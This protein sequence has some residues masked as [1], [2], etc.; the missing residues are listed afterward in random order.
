MPCASLPETPIYPASV[1]ERAQKLAKS[2]R[3]ILQ[4]GRSIRP[5]RQKLTENHL[6]PTSPSMRV[7][8]AV[9][10]SE[11]GLGQVCRR[12]NPFEEPGN[13]DRCGIAEFAP[14]PGHDRFNHVRQVAPLKICISGLLPPKRRALQIN[15]GMRVPARIMQS[16]FGRR[17][18]YSLALT[19]LVTTGAS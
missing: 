9:A 16:D 5:T 12:R 11:R 10:P 8:G 19:H 15:N 3:P 2:Y 1:A 14:R 7:R 13:P 6:S 4:K 17:L 18:S